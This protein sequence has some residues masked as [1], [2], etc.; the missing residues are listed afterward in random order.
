MINFDGPNY[1]ITLES[2]VTSV[3]AAE[4]YSAWKDWVLD[5]D[6]SKYLP[7]FRTIGGDDL[8][9]GVSLDG[10]F[11]LQNQHGWRIKPPEEDIN[12]LVNGNIYGE[13]PALPIRTGTVGDFNTSIDFNFSSRSQAVATS[14]NAFTLEDIKDAVW[15]A[16]RADHQ[17]SG[18]MGEVQGAGGGGSE[19]DHRVYIDLRA[20]SNGTGLA[21]DPFNNWAD[22]Y[23]YAQANDKRHIFFIGGL[24]FPALEISDYVGGYTLETKSPVGIELTF[25]GPNPDFNLLTLRGNFSVNKGSDAQYV[26]AYEGVLFGQAVGSPNRIPAFAMDIRLFGADKVMDPIRNSSLIAGVHCTDVT[27][28]MT[29]ASIFSASDWQKFTGNVTL[30]NMVTNS[31]FIFYAAGGMI[32]IAASCTAGT[33][34]IYGDA[35][36]VDE[37]AGTIVED[38]R[39]ESLMVPG[40]ANATR[41]LFLSTVSQEAGAPGTIRGHQPD[42]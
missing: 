19:E 21:S 33:V 22:T 12:I 32:T 34:K 27:I 10:Y 28:D 5:S 24:T 18:S 11:F 4:I 23:A 30:T 29:N 8:G 41:D 26:E 36:I 31:S 35:H 9:G 6:N 39:L 15:D 1:L 37:S 16:A 42:A 14:G 25:P 17:D 3:Q 20:S 38:Y 40:V 2:G 7:A 13:N